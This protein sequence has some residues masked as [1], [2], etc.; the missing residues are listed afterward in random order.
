MAQVFYYVDLSKKIMNIKLV[1]VVAAVLLFNLNLDAQGPPIRTDKPIMLGQGKSTVRAYYQYF[2]HAGN[3]YH[4]YPL[5][6]DYNLRNNIELGVELPFAALSSEVRRE[7]LRFGDAMLKA[8][9]QFYRKDS[10]AKTVRAGAKLAG[11]FPTGR[12]SEVPHVGM[13]AYQTILGVFAGM[14]SLKYGIV[15]ELAYVH[16]DRIHPKFVESRLAFGLPLLTPKYP[17]RQV[18]L[19]FE[20]E[21]RWM[22]ENNDH[23]A[24]FAQGIQWAFGRYALEASFQ[25]PLVEK[26]PHHFRRDMAIL[27]GTR[28]II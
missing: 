1:I 5:M 13:G 3:H 9:Y 23:A 26:V 25:M 27:V 21:G 28:I 16:F 14:E 2:K 15:G 20:Y 22:P 7:G 8:K 11:M 17:I 19:Y 4:L 24:Y 18:T 10:H 6:Y 12:P